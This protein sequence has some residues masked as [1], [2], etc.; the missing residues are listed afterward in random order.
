MHIIYKV[1]TGEPRIMVTSLSMA[2]A[3][4][5]E[6][7]AHLLTVSE[8]IPFENILVIDGQVTPKD[9]P[10]F[11]PV[12]AARH[13]RGGLLTDTDWTQAVDSPLS[14]ETKLSW[15]EYREELRDFPAMIAALFEQEP[16]K[17]S[18]I[19]LVEELVPVLPT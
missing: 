19:Y 17:V 3:N 14:V 7:E 2:E 11:D 6:G 15:K 10:A 9:I 1:S 18:S 16:D 4:L 8:D 5:E 13:L 12:A